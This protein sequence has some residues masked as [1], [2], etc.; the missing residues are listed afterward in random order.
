MKGIILLSGLLLVA[1]FGQAMAQCTGD[2]IGDAPNEL[3][4][5]L[6]G[7]LVCGTAVSGNDRWQEEHQSGGV[8]FERARGPLDPVDPSH[9]VGTWAVEARGATTGPTRD[10]VVCYSY[11]GDGTYCYRLYNDNGTYRYCDATSGAEV[12]TATFPSSGGC[13]F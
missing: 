7:K 11:T 9:V 4:N 6:R 5:F 1:A 8:L 10:D 2:R 12:V 3:D 13:G